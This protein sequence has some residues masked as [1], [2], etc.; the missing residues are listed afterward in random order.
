MGAACVPFDGRRLETATH[1]AG[2]M[3]ASQP[4]RRHSPTPSL[5]PPTA[6]FDAPNTHTNTHP[7]QHLILSSPRPFH[8]APLL[9]L[10]S[11][12]APRPLSAAPA[13]VHRPLELADS[14]GAP[15]ASRG[16]HKTV[17][18]GP[19]LGRPQRR[20]AA[21][22]AWRMP[23]RAVLETAPD[24]AAPGS[25]DLVLRSVPCMPPPSPAGA[26]LVP[27]QRQPKP[28]GRASHASRLR[29]GIPG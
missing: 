25:P 21:G 20:A 27:A 14:C 2:L 22:C 4:P 23:A 3:P 18:R 9:P 5:T 28:P 24:S 7:E 16:E 17:R 12:D 19:Q 10:H 15:R 1:P 13:S 29:A 8:P 6:V 26:C 11:A